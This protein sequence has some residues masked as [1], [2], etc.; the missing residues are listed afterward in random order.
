MLGTYRVGD[1]RFCRFQSTRAGTLGGI[2]GNT[3]GLGGRSFSEIGY[4]VTSVS[5]WT[6]TTVGYEG[7]LDVREFFL[8]DCFLVDC[9]FIGF[10]VNFVGLQ[11]VFGCFFQI[12]IGFLGISLGELVQSFNSMFAGFTGVFVGLL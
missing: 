4:F 3:L 12:F 2:D 9:C 5:W 6:T 1:G 7:L 10:V 11:D 8:V